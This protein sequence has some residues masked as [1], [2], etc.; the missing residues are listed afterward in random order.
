MQ[1]MVAHHSQALEMT[2]LLASR[3][4]REDMRLLG[5][6]IELSQADEIQLMRE[7]LNARRVPLSSHDANHAHPATAMPGMLTADEMRRLAEA[8]DGEFD[9][10]FLELMIKHHEGA[11]TMVDDLFAAVGAGQQSDIFTFASDVDA[12]QRMEI[13]RMGA[14]LREL[15]K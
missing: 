9:R 10:L 12:D 3:S 4:S 8:T 15:Q 6:R 11:L 1:A 13:D 2:G 7:W 5:R 14:M